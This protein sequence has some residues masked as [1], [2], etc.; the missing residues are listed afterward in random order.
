M[1]VYEVFK[2]TRDGAP[3]FVEIKESEYRYFPHDIC[4]ITPE[5]FR[6]HYFFK[7][8]Q[9]AQAFYDKS[10]KDFAELERINSV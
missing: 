3:P 7:T 9:A 5:G 2:D 1:I 6:K 4:Q 10:L 8:K